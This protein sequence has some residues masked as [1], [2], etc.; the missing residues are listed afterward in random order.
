MLSI[1]RLPGVLR[2]FLP[3]LIGRLSFAMVGLALLLTVQQSAGSFALAGFASALSGFANV[4]ASPWRARAVDRWGQRRALPVMAAVQAASL[5]ALAFVATS[6]RPAAGW[7]LALSAIIGLSVP[8]LGPSMRVIWSSLTSPGRQRQKAFSLDA[9]CEELL[10][11]SGPILITAVITATSPSVGLILA[12]STTVIGTAGMVLSNASHRVPRSAEASPRVD[13]PLSQPGFARVLVVLIGVGLVLGTLE[14]VAPAFATDRGEIELSGWLLA[15][16]A[17]GSAVGGLV[18]G[19]LRLA[20]S[21]VTR[22]L[23]LGI[24]LGVTVAAVAWAP[25]FVLLAAGLALAGVFLAPSLITGYLIADS[26]VP[27][28]GQTEA[29]AWINTTVN[30]GASFGAGVAGMV[31]DSWGTTAA[32][33]AVGIVAIA[34]ASTTPVRRLASIGMPEPEAAAHPAADTEADPAAA[35]S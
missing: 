4:I 25:T 34:L 2:A 6:Q 8:P 21:L 28:S 5:L 12:A 22:L 30:F 18:Y 31:I 3:A 33:L 20:A 9:T 19:H 23:V 7:F 10:F 26:A 1:L 32:L 24:G 16:F 13:R 14:I 17:A 29:S 15:T 11:V 27:K 35:A